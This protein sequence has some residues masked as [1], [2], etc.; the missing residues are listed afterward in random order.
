M[1]SPPRRKRFRHGPPPFFEGWAGVRL[2]KARKTDLRY[3]TLSGPHLRYS[4]TPGQPILSGNFLVYG[5]SVSSEEFPSLKIVVKSK[6]ADGRLT[7]LAE[8]RE[9]H[10]MF[11]A[12]LQRASKRCVTEAYTFRTA[13]GHT[14]FGRNSTAVEDCTADLVSVKST[15]K[16]GLSPEN[17]ACARKEAVVLLSMPEHPNI[18]EIVDVYESA[19]T[20]YLV[21]EHTGGKTLEDVVGE[22]GSLCEADVASIIKDLLQALVHMQRCEVIHRLICP[23]NVLIVPQEGDVGL[24]IAKLFNFE[25]AVS[26]MDVDDWTPV[27]DSFSHSGP[28][29]LRHALYLAPEVAAGRVGDYM[30]DTWSLG[31]LM[32]YLLV[33]CTPFDNGL[34]NFSQLTRTIADTRGSP[35][36]SGPLWRGITSRAKH[37]CASM[38][39]ADPR[40]R[41][42]A[43]QALEHPWL[44]M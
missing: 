29:Y 26:S 18:S 31:I 12:V 6:N 5:A 17:I 9:E 10:D 41:V 1:S 4:A 35:T 36:F 8:S 28:L 39:H 16:V 43:A 25:L 33:G 11:L 30:Q 34:T 15:C 22:R 21:T 7:I 3:C 20:V 19:R 37:L 27:M 40:M 13:L 23:E 32:H 42:T 44:N 2:G 14:A 24:G 38:L